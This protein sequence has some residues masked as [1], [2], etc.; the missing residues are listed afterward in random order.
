MKSYISRKFP[1]ETWTTDQILDLR[2][3]EFICSLC[4]GK[5]ASCARVR[6]RTLQIPIGRSLYSREAHRLEKRIPVQLG[7][8]DVIRLD[9]VAKLSVTFALPPIERQ[10]QERASSPLLLSTTIRQ[11]MSFRPN[12]MSRP[13]VAV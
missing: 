9:P 4:R 1:L 7:K 10:K 5:S 11:K 2:S 8:T 6:K 3:G 13:S 12:W